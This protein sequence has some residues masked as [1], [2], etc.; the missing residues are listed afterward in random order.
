MSITKLLLTSL[1]CLALISCGGGGGGGGGQDDDKNQQ[2]FSSEE[3]SIATVDT[4]GISIESFK[5]DFVAP[6]SI[7][8]PSSPIEQLKSTI[9]AY[10]DSQPDNLQIRATD[11]TSN[12]VNG[13]CTTLPPGSYTVS[14]SVTTPDDSRMPYPRTGF[15]DFVYND[16][17]TQVVINGDVFNSIFDGVVYFDFDLTSDTD[18]TISYIWDLRI[19]STSPNG[20]ES[21]DIYLSET[22]VISNRISNCTESYNHRS[23]DGTE[24]ELS[25]TTIDGSE[26]TG[27]TIEGTVSDNN[28]NSYAIS[29]QGLKTCEN[30]NFSE[31]SGTITINNENS[32]FIKFEDCNT[33]TVTYDGVSNLYN[34]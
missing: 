13:N 16:Y 9:S 15:A 10:T 27:F 3:V 18:G 8:S 32:I 2:A 26:D 19:T 11:T 34:Y 23:E 4:L 33:F 20:L 7:N 31:G 29:F 14:S 17:C 5:G 25:E 28:G 6:R 30:G 22:C 12:T 1:S 21:N 24:Y